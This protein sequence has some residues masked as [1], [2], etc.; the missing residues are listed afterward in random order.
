MTRFWFNFVRINQPHPI[1]LG[2]GVTAF[3]ADDAMLLIR[4]AFPNLALGSPI[5]VTVNID[6][7]TLDAGHVLPNLG[8]PIVRG[9]WWPRVS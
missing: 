3:S 9:I 4:A 2:C 7:S 5:N 6:V 1:N 8:N